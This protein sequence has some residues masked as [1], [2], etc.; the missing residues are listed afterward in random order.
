MSPVRTLLNTLACFVVLG[1]VTFLWHTVL[2]QSMYI[3]PTLS[4]KS[5][6]GL[7]PPH[8]MGGLLL[9]A[10]G[11]AFFIPQMLGEAGRMAKGVALGALFVSIAGN[12]HNLYLMGLYPGIDPLSLY[13]MD[14]AWA[15]IAGAV[16]GGVLAGADGMLKKRFAK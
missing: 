13:L 1:P 8:I 3:G 11:M 5:P 15:A 14:T 16:A 10:F 4:V 12:Y 6:E 2:F 9:V 7:S